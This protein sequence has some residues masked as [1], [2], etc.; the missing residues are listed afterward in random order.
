ML[1]IAL[2]Q[3][4]IPPNVGNAG[5]TCVGLG[6]TLHLIGPHQL[7]YSQHAVKRAGLDYWDH[8]TWQLHDTP[9][10]FLQW[11]GA[12]RLWLV[13]KHGERR[14]DEPDYQDEDVLIFGHEKA[15]LP[16]TWLEHWTKQ[17]IYVPIV[18]AI[19]S[20]NLAN[21]VAMVGAQAMVKADADAGSSLGQR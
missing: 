11:A 6:A 21:T 3:P 13:T 14:F 10:A 20:Y 19:R 1:H 7:D 15:G 9:E 5:R 18:G 12:R 2:Y 8:L 17:T 16:D 4:V